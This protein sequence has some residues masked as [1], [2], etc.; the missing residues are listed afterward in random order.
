MRTA[1][2]ANAAARRGHAVWIASGGLPVHGLD[3]GAGRLV[4]LPPLAAAD[5]SFRRLVD[6]RGRDVD[7]DW[8]ERRRAALDAAIAEARPQ[9]FVVEQFPFGRR[10]LARELVPVLERARAARVSVICSVRDVLTA[11]DDP[12]R[13]REMAELARRLCD[14][15]LVHGD[16]RV[17]PFG[18]SFPAADTIADLVHYTGYV[19]PP[20]APKTERGDEILVSAG[21]GAVGEPLLVAA[22]DAARQGR[23]PW[24]IL[25]G[26]GIA[27]ARFDALVAA[28]PANALVE[29][30]RADFRALLARCAVSVSQGGYNTVLETLTAGARAV[31]VPFATDGQ[32]EQSQRARRMAALGLVDV[33]DEATLSGA[34]LS[35]AVAT[36]LLRPAGGTPALDVGGAERTVALIEDLIARHHADLARA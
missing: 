31:I 5:A 30:N 24:R 16:P 2:I 15:V 19:A 18:A 35:G 27:A 10:K 23:H 8:W 14:T 7:A 17:L 33:V 29:R 9:A 21:G 28:A 3:L 22:L 36:A 4:Q 13:D 1:L 11:R 26:G 34:T 20:A 12:S 6:E 25:A 32:T